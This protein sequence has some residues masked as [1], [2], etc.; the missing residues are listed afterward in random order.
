[1]SPN[2]H[3]GGGGNNNYF[4]YAGQWFNEEDGHG[5]SELV[6]EPRRRGFRLTT[7]GVCLDGWEEFYTGDDFDNHCEWRL[8]R[9]YRVRGDY[10]YK[11]EYEMYDHDDCVKV[12]VYV[13]YHADS[14]R[15]EVK[16]KWKYCHD[17][18]WYGWYDEY[19]Y[20]D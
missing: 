7:Y 10:D 18:D 5:I 8:K 20:K 19:F 15:L 11:F 13:K 2:H 1:V 14:G 9:G 12:I 4:P 3:G 16:W 6:F 17:H